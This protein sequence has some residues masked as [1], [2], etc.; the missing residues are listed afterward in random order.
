MSNLS[1]PFAF[2]NLLQAPAPQSGY[3]SSNVFVRN[4]GL[5]DV[6]VFDAQLT[7]SV[8]DGRTVERIQIRAYATHKEHPDHAGRAV[9]SVFVPDQANP[10][11]SDYNYYSLCMLADAVKTQTTQDGRQYGVADWQI[12]DAEGYG[13]TPIKEVTAL[14]DKRFVIALRVGKTR[15]GKT[16][17]NVDAVF[18][19]DGYSAGE[20]MQGASRNGAPARDITNFTY[21]YEGNELEPVQGGSSSAAASNANSFRTAPAQPAAQ[22]FQAQQAPQYQ[23]YAQAAAAQA[24]QAYA[25]QPAQAF[26]QQ[27][28][29]SFAQQPAPQAPQAPQEPQYQ[30]YGQPQPAQSFGQQ[31]QQPQQQ[32]QDPYGSMQQGPQPVDPRSIKQPDDYYPYN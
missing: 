31:Q 14:K 18:N 1:T 3:T 10:H 22:S 23:S 28:A 30:N 29:Q 2:E 25:P 17:L 12:R 24:P 16:V 6:Q 7:S 11:P 15:Q 32:Q 13:G 5:Y 21:H 26:S 19:K 8:R 27:G 4:S 20:V 9:F